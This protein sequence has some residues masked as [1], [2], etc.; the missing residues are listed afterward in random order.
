MTTSNL[1]KRIKYERKH[2][3]NKEDV[4]YLSQIYKVEIIQNIYFIALG[5]PNMKFIRSNIVFFPIYIILFG[6]VVG[7]LG[8]YE[9]SND[10]FRLSSDQSSYIYDSD[11]DLDLNKFGKA[12]LY[13]DYRLVL[14]QVNDLTRKKSKA[15]K[16]K[17][18]DPI[19]SKSSEASLIA[20]SNSS[21]GESSQRS[22]KKI[23]HMLKK[24]LLLSD[25]RKRGTRSRSR[26][27]SKSRSG[28]DEEREDGPWIQKYLQNRSDTGSYVIKDNEGGG[29]CLY[30][31]IRDAYMASNLSKLEKDNIT[32]SYLRKLIVSNINEEQFLEY[33]QIYDD[34]RN[35]QA[36]LER[37]IID[38]EKKLRESKNNFK[39]V[40]KIEEIREKIEENENLIAE[41]QDAE[42]INTLAE[43]REKFINCNFWANGAAINQLEQILNVKLII[44]SNSN[45]FQGN[46]NN[47]IQCGEISKY[48]SQKGPVK[49]ILLD[50]IDN[51]HYRLIKY[52]PKK[53]AHHIGL[54]SFDELPKEIIKKV[55][56]QCLQRKTGAFY[57]IPEFQRIADAK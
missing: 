48:D 30:A 26:S 6:K 50:Y 13:N 20:S 28:S 15:L 49:Y 16:E 4:N 46:Y 52:K 40:K 7:Q 45:Y 5:R 23:Q 3:L 29:D 18:L 57:V 55:E 41:F 8:L 22:T 21:S 14:N 2:I 1:D 17:L 37:D 53:T 39:E 32:V 25:E 42:N 12:I 27:K 9:I 34:L 51:V 33:K 44:F 47:V 19:S 36:I 35:E 31:A 10:Q 24:K 11:G 56:Q 54:F 38:E 43:Y